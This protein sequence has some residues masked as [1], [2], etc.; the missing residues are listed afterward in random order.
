MRNSKVSATTVAILMGMMACGCLVSAGEEGEPLI[1][2]KPASDTLPMP[3]A[4]Y[5]SDNMVYA[6]QWRIGNYVRIEAMVINMTEYTS[7]QDIARTDTNLYP[8][9]YKDGPAQQQAMLGDPAVLNLT[10]MVSVSYIEITLL[11]ST[12]GA[13]VDQFEAGWDDETLNQVIYGGVGREVNKAGH[14]IYGM[15]WDTSGLD[16]GVYTVE[17]RLGH[18]EFVGDLWTRVIG[19]WYSVNNATANWYNPEE[20]EGTLMNEEHPY[21]DLVL[22]GTDD[23]SIYGI[24]V[25]GVIA[26]TAWIDLGPLIP[27]GPGGGSGG[28]G[29]SHGEEGDG[30]NHCG[31]QSGGNGNG[32]NRYRK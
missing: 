14:L 16:A 18:V 25:G 9:V 27:Q 26:Q 31:E 6:P 15:L 32:G 7:S 19:D 10:R 17:V 1:I 8:E 30:N 3:C 23:Y 21:H 2:T 11:N 24:G 22:D 29:G 5:F 12:T 20:A 13:V 4:V 28:D